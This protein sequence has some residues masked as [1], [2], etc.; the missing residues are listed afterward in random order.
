MECA[1]LTPRLPPAADG[2]LPARRD[3]PSEP[4][5][6]PTGSRPNP[7]RRTRHPAPA[8]SRPGRPPSEG[9]DS[10]PD[11]AGPVDP[12]GGD[13]R[14]DPPR[15]SN[16]TLPSWARGDE[17]QRGGMVGRIVAGRAP[18]SSC[19]RPGGPPRSQTVRG[20]GGAARLRRRSSAVADRSSGCGLA[21]RF[22][23][24]GDDRLRECLGLAV[25][26]ASTPPGASRL[27]RERLTELAERVDVDLDVVL[28]VLHRDRPLLLV[29]GRSER[30]RGSPSTGRRPSRA[31]CGSPGSP[32]S[33]SAASSDRTRIPSRRGPPCAPAGRSRRSPGCSLRRAGCPSCRGC[34]TRRA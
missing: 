28:G 16:R 21:I 5:P 13:R 1:A 34:R 7:R 10:R 31:R 23:R 33:W 8:G 12:A 27:R 29:A 15:R 24:V 32:G 19:P 14:A 17:R 26:H 30:S 22:T 3:Q 4:S 25:T 18:R 11:R 9:L 2:R 6:T 20:D